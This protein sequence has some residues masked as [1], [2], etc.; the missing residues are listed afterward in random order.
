MKKYR[1]AILTSILMAVLLPS[2]SLS[3]ALCI[4]RADVYVHYNEHYRNQY[5]FSPQRGWISDPCGFV[6]RDGRYHCYWWGC[7]ESV[8]LVHF[9][10]ISR[11]VHKDVP[12]GLGCWTG[13]V[14]ADTANT[15]GF[16]K[17][18]YVAC[19]TFND[20]ERKNQSQ[21]LTVSHDGGRTFTYYEGNP[22]LDI[23]YQDFRDPTIIW[24]EATG[25]WLMVVSKTLESKVAFYASED[26]KQWTWL[27]DFGPAGRTYRCF[28]C[29]DLFELEV[30]N[31]PM[32]GQKKWV[33]VVSVDWDNEQYFVGDFDGTTFTAEGLKQETGVYV[34]CGP[35]FYAS[36]TFKDFDGTLGGKVYSMGWMSNWRYCRD[37]PT[38]YGKGFWSIPRELSLRDTPEGWRLVQKPKK[39]IY[40]LRGNPQ[41]FE[42]FLLPGRTT[43]DAVGQLGNT[44]EA[45]VG[46]DT[47]ISNTFGIN[48]CAGGGRKLV[49]TYDTESH[50]L[51][52]DRSQVADFD[53]PKFETTC[54]AKVAPIDG[55][56]KLDIFVDRCSVEIFSEDGTCVFSLA[57][58]TADSHT[59]F[60]L[61]SQMPGT[62][63]SMS[64]W[65]MRS[66]WP[67]GLGGD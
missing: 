67:K 45:M 43:I 11:H 29:P 34:D 66:I 37:L 8:D 35:D 26:L 38:T 28:E 14:V 51:V 47:S 39:E 3:A 56:L 62:A 25:R 42:G 5:H 17:E 44:Y 33:L 15:A 18:A 31:G 27:S 55:W 57:T 61:F 49:I 21:G 13:C 41:F 40:S 2:E 16:G 48:L 58:F 7:A 59:A 9:T 52:V 32:K 63:Y 22:V 19:L 50:S 12:R 1:I 24:H 46:F 20:G 60:E 53:M 23:G 36:R 64:V 65:P 4:G 6:Y 30:D 10:E 54:H